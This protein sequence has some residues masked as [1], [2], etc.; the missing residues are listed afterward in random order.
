MQIM[1]SATSAVFDETECQPQLRSDLDGALGRII[2]GSSFITV[3]AAQQWSTH[4]A[5]A[6]KRGVV[7][8]VL[9]QEPFE[10]GRRQDNRLAANTI[11]KLR[12]LEAAVDLLQSIGVHVILRPKMH[13]KIIVVED[14]ILWDGSINVLSWFDTSERARRW[15]DR[16]E[17]AQAIV[18]HDLL[19]CTQCRMQP[20]GHQ[21]AQRRLHRGLSQ[22]EFA[23]MA[24]TYRQAIAWAE[25]GK[26]DV[27]FGIIHRMCNALDCQLVVVPKHLAGAV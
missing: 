27:G 12:A 11:A 6:I 23:R 5:S 7:V 4:F 2:I 13:E 14:C 19:S 26:R 1:G 22:A 18:K 21:L 24:D 17:V 25:S 8:C 10:W 9:I 20:V 16:S 15:S 3:R